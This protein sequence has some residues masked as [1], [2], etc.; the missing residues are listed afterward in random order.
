ML[1]V[2][3]FKALESHKI[4]IEKGT[5]R[6]YYNQLNFFTDW[7]NA[8]DLNDLPPEEFTKGNAI[9]FLNSLEGRHNT[10][11]TGYRNNLRAVFNLVIESRDK[12]QKFENPFIGIRMPKISHSE[13]KRAFTEA[14]VEN[15]K[16]HC[17]QNDLHEQWLAFQVIFYCMLRPAKELRLLKVG[18]IDLKEQR[19]LVRATNAKND[20]QQFVTI[21]NQL[22]SPLKQWIDSTKRTTSDYLF[23]ENGKPRKINYF[24]EHC[25]RITEALH[26]GRDATLYSWKH[27]GAV[28]FYKE[29]KDIVSL[30]RQIRHANLSETQGYLHSLGLLENE[31]AKDKFP[32]I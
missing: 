12:G 1:S 14:E 6:T 22:I 17:Q 23:G 20:K 21:P 16:K 5:Y 31:V 8:N 32:T 29:T 13:Q 10:T 18:D 2:T 25:K 27:T 7:L 9:A 11:R 15:I 28:F 30:Q 24:Y 26:I 4:N 19:I 3:L